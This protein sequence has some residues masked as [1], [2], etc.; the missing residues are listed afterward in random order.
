MV[1]YTKNWH[2]VD[3]ARICGVCTTGPFAGGTLRMTQ[4]GNMLYIHTAR[5]MYSASDGRRHQSNISF[6]VYI[7]TMEALEV[8]SGNVAHSF[9]QFVIVDGA[10]VVHLDHGDGHP[11]ALQIARFS[12]AA[13]S[14]RA[15]AVKSE[16]FPIYGERGQNYTG[17]QVG[18]FEASGTHYL[19]AGLSIEQREDG[20]DFQN[21]FVAAT[22]KA[23]LGEAGDTTVRWLTDYV[24]KRD[25]SPETDVDNPQLVKLGEDRFLLLWN[26]NMRD[27]YVL[28]ELHVTLHYVFLKGDG[29]P[30]S[31]VYTF[32]QVP[33]SDC[34][35]IVTGDGVVWYVTDDSEPTFY[36]IDLTDP[37][38]VTVTSAGVEKTSV[39]GF[40]DVW[41]ADYFAEP[42]AWA[43]KK[44]V[45]SGTAPATFSPD[46]V[47]TRAQTVT[48]LW[49]SAGCPAP[50]SGENPFKD[51]SSGDYFYDAVLWAVEQGITKGT[52][53]DAF[54]PYEPCTRGQVVTF[55]WRYEKSPVQGSNPFLD[56]PDGQYYTQAVLWAVDRGIT[57]G[58]DST[59]FSPDQDCTRAQIVTFLYRDQTT[60]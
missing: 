54:S 52:A 37:A 45:T 25:G 47:C 32:D 30:D 55:L 7:P 56:V 60:G 59:H 23:R 58:T 18:G 48:F 27:A 22:E 6:D 44:G 13:G 40:E 53:D 3:D 2:R 39:G 16:I 21:L 19:T 50:E 35:P 33:L 11:R 38:G 10:D 41:S 1:R 9:N 28:S 57:K 12:N 51:I 5:Q 4:S 8:V 43:V 36:R 31:E 49:R 29:S 17:V 24:Y 14:L 15:A 42:V 26:E 34:A 20:N 46:A